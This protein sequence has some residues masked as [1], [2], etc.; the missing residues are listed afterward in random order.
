MHD[1]TRRLWA[2]TFRDSRGEEVPGISVFDHCL[3]V[4]WV[5]QALAAQLPSRVRALLPGPNGQAAAVLAA[6]HDIG[7]LTLGFQVKC[8]VWSFPEELAESVRRQAQ[9]SVS[10]HALVS[11]VFLQD[12]LRDS[13]T[14]LWAVAIGAPPSRPAERAKGQ[15]S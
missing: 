10:D 13:G 14:Q 1:A 7:K 12:L 2:K 5:A 3:N 8:T 11:Q 9:S 15:A 6:L 4:G